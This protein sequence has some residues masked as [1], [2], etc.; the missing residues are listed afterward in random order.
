[1]KQFLAFC[2]L[3]TFSLSGIAQ[4][5]EIWQRNNDRG[6]R[7]EG[8]RTQKVNSTLQLVGLHGSFEPYTFSEAQ[9][10]QVAF[11][12]DTA[13]TIAVSAE[14]LKRQAYY[15]MESKP[16]EVEAGANTF[17]PWEVDAVLAEEK[18]PPE[19][20]AIL[21]QQP[22]ADKK[23]FLPAFVYHSHAP[24]SA[25][26]YKAYF[27]A[28]KTIYNYRYRIYEGKNT[29][30]DN[31]LLSKFKRRKIFKN[32]PFT[33]TIDFEDLDIEGA[34]EG[35]YTMEL[36]MQTRPGIQRVKDQYEFYFYHR[37]AFNE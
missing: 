18:I 24:D 2:F 28:G 9:V 6:N 19:N 3:L 4:D 10:L 37:P 1:M 12:A 15:W 14:E 23:S 17:G 25:L 33:I 36:I 7:F 30:K 22:E 21:V 26:L 27:L 35:W 5:D 11:Y 31:R 16:F 34:A 13:T 20:L 32:R 29:D 8:T